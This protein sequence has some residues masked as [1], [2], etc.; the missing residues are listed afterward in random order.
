MENFKIL[1]VTLC[2]ILNS[3]IQVHPS[4]FFKNS[5]LFS[6]CQEKLIKNYYLFWNS[7]ST[8]QHRP[9]TEAN[10]YHVQLRMPSSWLCETHGTDF[11][12][13]GYRNQR[14]WVAILMDCTIVGLSLQG[15]TPPRTLQEP[16]GF[17]VS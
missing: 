2:L 12:V 7:N 1:K 13:T 5:I 4:L 8:T 9:H 10:R 16:I 15:N 3:N 17:Y 11:P 14:S 6:D